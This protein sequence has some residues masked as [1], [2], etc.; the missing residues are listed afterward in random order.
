MKALR[1]INLK[2]KKNTLNH[3]V[4]F[5]GFFLTNKILFLFWKTKSE[6]TTNKGLLN[7]H[8]ELFQ[9]NDLP[10]L[11]IKLSTKVNFAYFFLETIN[12]VFPQ[13]QTACNIQP[14]LF[15]LFTQSEDKNRNTFNSEY[16][17]LAIT[18]QNWKTQISLKKPSIRSTE[19]RNATR[20]ARMTANT[21]SRISR[22][23]YEK[24]KKKVL[25]ANYIQK[26][27]EENSKGQKLTTDMLL[28]A[29]QLRIDSNLC[30]LFQ[31]SQQRQE[32]L[33]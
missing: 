27:V 17:Q 19:P 15:L 3:H 1:Y 22:F 33:E 7:K 2:R 20:I 6:S 5:V 31:Y 28:V 25:K 14:K 13:L 24:E 18:R 26:K 4:Q 10:K 29:K 8:A 32:L 12:T 23:L 9:Q 21:F 11:S 16:W 30:K